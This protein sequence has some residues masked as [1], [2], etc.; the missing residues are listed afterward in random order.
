MTREERARRIGQAVGEILVHLDVLRT[1]ESLQELPS[2]DVEAEFTAEEEDEHPRMVP[3]PPDADLDDDPEGRP[4]DREIVT[5]DPP[6]DYE[7][8][9]M[10]EA[11]FGDDGPGVAITPE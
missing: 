4:P 10:E 2:R 7:D 6:K 11:G 1:L 5:K 9:F 3:S 8:V